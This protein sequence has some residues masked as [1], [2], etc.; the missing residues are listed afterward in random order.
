[1]LLYL[2]EDEREQILK[3]PSLDSIN[4]AVREIFT[5]E[6]KYLKKITADFDT[7]DN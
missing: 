5:R 3:E 7:E 2:R 6:N 1:M 4:S